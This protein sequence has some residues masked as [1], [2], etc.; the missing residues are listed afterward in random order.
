MLLLVALA[1]ATETDR[2]SAEVLSVTEAA[3]VRVECRR[4]G[5]EARI[6]L[7]TE[8]GRE[9][10]VERGDRPALSPDATE[11]VWVQ[12][13]VASVW[14]MSLQEREPVQLTNVGLVGASPRFVPPP[15]RGGL[16]FDGAT[17]TWDSPEGPQS[18][19]AP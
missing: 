10:L 3:G 13:P 8:G 11:L 15:H 7:V 19:A 1:Q 18:V 16:V 6:E 17:V 14:W 9:V 5:P 2:L 12:G 4:E